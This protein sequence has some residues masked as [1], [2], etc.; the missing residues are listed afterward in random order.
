MTDMVLVRAT[1]LQVIAWQAMTQEQASQANESLFSESTL[2]VTDQVMWITK[3][4]YTST[5]KEIGEIYDQH[6]SSK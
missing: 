2:N 6:N 3:S 1:D 4:V 5:M